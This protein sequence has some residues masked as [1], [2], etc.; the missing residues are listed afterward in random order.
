MFNSQ[1]NFSSPF[2]YCLPV[3]QQPIKTK[4]VIL[5]SFSFPFYCP[6]F[7]LLSLSPLRFYSL[8]LYPCF[9]LHLQTL[10]VALN[11]GKEEKILGLTYSHPTAFLLPAIAFVVS[12]TFSVSVWLVCSLLTGFHLFYFSSCLSCCITE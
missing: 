3:A 12:V 11:R 7:F 2:P 9:S 4:A 1:K 10:I 6:N 5:L 8:F